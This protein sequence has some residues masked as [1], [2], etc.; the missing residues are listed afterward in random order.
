MLS[1]RRKR[2]ADPQWA[3]VTPIEDDYYIVP[4]GGQSPG[5]GS[6]RHSGEEADPFL[7]RNI[8][9]RPSNS[10]APVSIA[11]AGQNDGSLS[12][13][14]KSSAASG[15]GT[16]LERPSL[17][18]ST[19]PPEQRRGRILSPE[20]LRRIDQESVLPPN[21]DFGP[22]AHP[23]RLVS[24]SSGLN[25]PLPIAGSRHSITPSIQSWE[26]IN[27]AVTIMHKPSQNSMSV[28]LQ[29]EPTVATAR[30]VRMDSSAVSPPSSPA[31]G[32]SNRRTSWKPFGLG[33]LAGLS[34]LSWFRNSDST[35]SSKRA[36]FLA[37]A[38][39]D[40]D[41]EAG[42]ALLD[43]PSTSEPRFRR[44]QEL[45][46]EERPISTFSTKSG[47]TVYHDAQSSIPGTPLLAPP[48]RALP[49][50]SFDSEFGG[51][52][53]VPALHPAEPSETTTTTTTHAVDVDILD[54]P[55][56][57]G[58]SPFAS[59]SSL[60]NTSTTSSVSKK[61]Y[62]H[63]PGLVSE[64]LPTPAA[65]KDTD[66]TTPSVGSFAV[67]SSGDGNR[68]ST[69]ITVDVLEEAPPAAGQSWRSLAGTRSENKR[70]T[71]GLVRGYLAHLLLPT[72]HAATLYADT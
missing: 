28:S 39:T 49:S 61:A 19:A 44:P 46:T 33:G 60:R 5:E 54:M 43:E 69:G 51:W 26:L 8:Q 29:D 1:S 71:F 70:T 18:V 63:P 55:A 27:P 9:M 52:P 2:R 37:T 56:P 34:R 25:L 41:V 58:I 50:D 36:S 13:S 12:S 10:G 59:T 4:P 68:L 38:L 30:R 32:S 21:T 48:P 31:E 6:P 57:R 35:P 22:A 45:A 15:Y 65:W 17:A 66:G 72:L 42:R 24:S 53:G 67:D 64:D 47:L 14:N 40:N 11:G 23:P 7:N 62:P 20:E 16:L 3:M